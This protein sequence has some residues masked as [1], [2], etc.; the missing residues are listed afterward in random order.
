MIEHHFYYSYSYINKNLVI[1]WEK[2]SLA[3]MRNEEIFF[4]LFTPTMR[5]KNVKVLKKE[6]KNII[7]YV[8]E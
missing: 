4:L 2:L 5:S 7:A 8:K 1:I 3:Y 6:Q